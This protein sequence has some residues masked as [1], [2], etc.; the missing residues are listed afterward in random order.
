[1]PRVGV[2]GGSFNPIH[3]GHLLLADEICEILDLDRVLFVPAAEPPHKPPVDLAPARHRFQMTALAIREH[4]RFEVSDVELR[5]SGPSY[6]VQTLEALWDRGDLSLMIGSE[7]FLDLL[8][9]REPWRVVRLARLVV[10]PRNST[11]FDPDAPSA[12]KVLKE[13]GLPGFVPATDA[14]PEAG[15]SPAAPVLVR[16]ASLPISGSDLRRRAR[17][18]RSLAFRMPESVVAYIRE[19]RLYGGD[20]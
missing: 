8:S 3:F 10:V 5:R 17:E 14:R 13:L 7:T 4:P 1:V 12:Q 18:G 2:F 11:G 9:W 19:H 20:A 15:L 6:T 16:A